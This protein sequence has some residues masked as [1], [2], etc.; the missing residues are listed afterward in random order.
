MDFERLDLIEVIKIK[1]QIFSD[2]RGEFMECFKQAQFNKAVGFNVN[3]I[4]DNQSLSLQRY[5][6]RGLHFQSPPYSQGKLVKCVRGKIIDVAVDARK[7][8]PNY[9]KWVSA[10]LSD[11]NHEQL[12]IPEGFLHGFATLEPNTI[13]Q[14]KCTDY[15]TASADGNVFWNDKSL[16]ID[17]GFT[18][19]KAI[20]SRKDIIAPQFEDFDS[21]F[22][23]NHPH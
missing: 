12:W 7:G 15:Y 13:V 9:G 4:Q 16:K 10:M 19:A 3:F 17:W 8:S 6:V 11:K 14:Y 2:N 1:P 23:Y 20:L 5:T 22:R 21:P 18:P